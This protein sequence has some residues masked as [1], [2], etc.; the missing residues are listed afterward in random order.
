MIKWNDVE[1]II[2]N[3][4]TF[5]N[6]T[7]KYGNINAAFPFRIEMEYLPNREIICYNGSD[8][9]Y[10][11]LKDISSGS[12]LNFS[13]VFSIKDIYNKTSSSVNEG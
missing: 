5:I 9:C 8:N 11:S 3:N 12:L 4:N 2:Y 1:P 13:L 10:I 7:A 6:N